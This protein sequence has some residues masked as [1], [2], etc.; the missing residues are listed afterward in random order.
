MAEIEIG[1]LTRQCLDRRLT[2]QRCLQDQVAAWEKRRNTDR[3]TIEWTFSRQD[4]DRKLGPHY[5]S[6]L[7]C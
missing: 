7:T 1:V 2:D 6:K 5:V 3:R 4:A